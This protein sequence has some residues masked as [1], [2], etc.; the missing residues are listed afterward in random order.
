MWRSKVLLVSVE[1]DASCYYDKSSMAFK[2]EG[3]AYFFGPVCTQLKQ[4]DFYD[5]V[6]NDSN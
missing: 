3:G 1:I 5:R 2:E 4:E 6:V